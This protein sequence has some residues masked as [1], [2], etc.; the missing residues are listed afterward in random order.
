MIDFQRDS[1]DRLLHFVSTQVEVC[2]DLTT[3]DLE[4]R[5]QDPEVSILLFSVVIYVIFSCYSIV[6]FEVEIIY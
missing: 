3:K 2:R 4:K 1:L 6:I 5:K